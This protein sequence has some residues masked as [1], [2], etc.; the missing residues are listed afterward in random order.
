[1]RGERSSPRPA[2][3]LDVVMVS[4]VLVALLAIAVWF[5]AFAGSSLPS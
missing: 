1:M 5:F 2:T 3:V 4:S